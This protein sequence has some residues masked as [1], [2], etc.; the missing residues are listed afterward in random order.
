MCRQITDN[1]IVVTNKRRY[2]R[3]CSASK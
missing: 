1:N 2:N 3:V